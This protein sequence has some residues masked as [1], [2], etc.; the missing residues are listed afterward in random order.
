MNFATLGVPGLTAAAIYASGR[1]LINTQTGAP[2]G[3]QNETDVRVDYAFPKGTILEGLV[4]TLRYAWTHQ[5]DTT[6][7]GN[8]LRA[9]LNY[10]VR[11]WSLNRDGSSRSRIK[12]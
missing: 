3:N 4:A 6:Q 10:D 8:Q 9:Y 7:N 1:D 5:D 11:F 2:I 12:E